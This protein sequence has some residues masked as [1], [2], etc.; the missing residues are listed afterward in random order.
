MSRHATPVL[1]KP[2]PRNRMRMPKDGLQIQLA[3]ISR[4]FEE[5]MTLL[6]DYHQGERGHMPMSARR[7]RLWHRA[8][9][10]YRKWRQERDM[11]RMQQEMGMVV[12]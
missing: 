6:E 7:C 4:W 9:R 12:R 10:R 11:D 2:I 8:Y 1:E 3:E 5:D